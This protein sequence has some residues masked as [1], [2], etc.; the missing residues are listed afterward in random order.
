M[1]DALICFIDLFPLFLE[2][3]SK[4]VDLLFCQTVF[5][6]RNIVLKILDHPIFILNVVLDVLEIFRDLSIVFLLNPIDL[7]FRGLRN[8]KNILNSVSHN[9]VL[10]RLQPKD[11][12]I[13]DSG[14]RFFFVTAIISI[15]LDWVRELLPW[16]RSLLPI[17][18]VCLSLKFWGDGFLSPK[19]D[20]HL[21]LR[22]PIV[23]ASPTLVWELGGRPN[24]PLRLI[25]CINNECTP[26]LEVVLWQKVDPVGG[27]FAGYF[28][29]YTASFGGATYSLG[30]KL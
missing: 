21:P 23:W 27:R 19:W 17:V 7:L 15:L 8:W 2:T 28:D 5:I 22:W 20:Y 18:P 29:L 1:S 4:L 24:S 12:F 9:E 11:R 3:L 30:I 14:H 16:G 13:F 10:I 25:T 6:L 26:G